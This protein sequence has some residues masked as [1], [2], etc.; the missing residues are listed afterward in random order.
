MKRLL[1]LLIYLMCV[2]STYAQVDTTDQPTDYVLLNFYD[3][4]GHRGFCLGG[5]NTSKPAHLIDENESSYCVNAT[6]NDSMVLSPRPG[7]TKQNSTPIS[8]DNPAWGLYRYYPVSGSA[9]EIAACNGELWQWNANAQRFLSIGSGLTTSEDDQWNFTTFT[10]RAFAHNGEDAVQVIDSAGRVYECGIE[11]P[12]AAPILTEASGSILEGTYKYVYT[13][14]DNTTGTESRPS[15][16]ATI[17]LA[18]DDDKVQVSWTDAPSA[19][20]TARGVNLQVKIYRTYASGNIYYYLTTQDHGA[21]P[22]QYDTA[23]D[24][25]LG[26]EESPTEN[27]QPSTFSDICVY[28]G[29]LVACGDPDYPSRVYYSSLL[30]NQGPEAW[31]TGNYVDID[32]NDGTVVQRVIAIGDEVWVFKDRT[33]YKLLGGAWTSIFK[34]T[35]RPIPSSVGCAAPWSLVNA[36]GIA[37]FLSRVGENLA[38]YSYD[39]YMLEDE[40]RK[41]VNEL[42][43]IEPSA[44][45]YAAGVYADGKYRLAVQ[46]ERIGYS[47]NNKVYEFDVAT[48]SWWPLEGLYVNSWSYWDGAGD[49]GQL[50]FADARGGFICEYGQVARDPQMASVP[51][52]FRTKSFDLGKPQ[53]FK[54]WWKT[55]LDFIKGINKSIGI[56]LIMDYGRKEIDLV[57]DISDLFAVKWAD[58]GGDAKWGQF[59][60]GQKGN[61]Q[62]RVITFPKAAKSRYMAI[63]YED[64]P[65]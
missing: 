21:S 10:G 39:G 60:W 7:Y 38:V 26:S 50:Y 52:K 41:I 47:C 15:P 33:A 12:T 2:G 25:E 19:T 8:G 30:S 57:E 17:V 42:N 9:M 1:I 54:R 64:P 5:L 34:P 3:S 59:K 22:Y 45:K 32:S 11:A 65:S 48:G 20:C 14:Y 40:S 24:D 37:L 31:P 28:K 49:E 6:L 51:F 55:Y 4:P 18:D 16:I 61:V 27:Y 63:Q 29:Q 36:N 62:H 13:Y 56:K 46:D 23:Q 58:R 43:H 35:V 44:I 53:N